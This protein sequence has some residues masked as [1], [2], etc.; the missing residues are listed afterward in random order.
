MNQPL[1]RG[2]SAPILTPFEASGVV[3]YNE[4]GR[5]AA[6][7]TNNG[8]KSLFVCGTSGEFIN[9][10]M[11]ERKKLLV[12][13]QQSKKTGAMTLYNV[14]AMNVHDMAELCNW[15]TEQGVDAVSVTAPYY[16]KYDEQA[17]KDY[18]MI[19]AKLAGSL[20]LY[21]YNI[22]SMAGNVISAPLLAELAQR[23]PNIVGIKDSSMDFMTILEYQRMLGDKELEIVTGNDAQVLTAL[24]S[25]CCG[26]VIVTASV[27]PALCATIQNH[28]ESGELALARAAQQKVHALRELCRS[29]MPIMSHKELLNLQ[30]FNMGPARFPMRNLTEQEQQLVYDIAKGIGV[31]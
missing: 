18:F 13:A 12:T 4:F 16:H 23:C 25:G 24:M 15:A 17:L 27:F 11:E 26:S 6:H 29:I 3:N 10:T 8:V 30:G 1:M 2:V 5:L 14:T 22:P 19:C 28:Y 7:I 31:L 21:L 9:L 20:P